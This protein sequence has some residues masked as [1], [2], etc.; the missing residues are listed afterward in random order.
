MHNGGIQKPAIPKEEKMTDVALANTRWQT[1]S[2]PARWVKT[3]KNLK[4]KL[5]WQVEGQEMAETAEEEGNEG[6][7]EMS[8]VP[9]RERNEDYVGDCSGRLM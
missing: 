8:G 6:V 9:K 2:P 5:Q 7:T 3:K 1:I 4:K